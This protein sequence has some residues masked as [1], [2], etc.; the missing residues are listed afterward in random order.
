MSG[1]Q[2]VK[3]STESLAVKMP[4]HGTAAAFE[5]CLNRWN[6]HSAGSVVGRAADAPVILHPVIAD[7]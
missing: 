2:E 3:R 4:Q 7:V 6:E 5:R 1:V